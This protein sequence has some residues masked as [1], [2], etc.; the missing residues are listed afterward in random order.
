MALFKRDFNKPGPGVPKNAPQKKGIA[1]FWEILTRDFGSLVKLNLIYQL[2]L[3]PAQFLLVLAVIGMGSVGF[4]LFGALALVA[5]IL[6]GPATVAVYHCLIQIL[7]D[8]PGF[9]WHDFKDQFKSNFRTSV[10]PGIIYS[11]IIGAQIFGV[12][13]YMQGNNAIGMVFIVLFLFS[14]LIFAMATPYFFAQQAFVDLKNRLM[15]QNS[16]IMALG[17]APRS[18]VGALFGTGL[19]IVQVLLFPLSTFLTPFIGYTIPLLINLM[20]VWP[21]VDKAFKIDETLKQRHDDEMD[22]YVNEIDA[23]I[24]TDN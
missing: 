15:L 3:F 20:W 17:Y 13:F 11:L 7:R 8:Q 10:I 5:S 14:V 19:I 4:L 9:V 23:G 21:Q 24:N 12:F 18:F 6:V 1:R 2:C 16:V 22:E